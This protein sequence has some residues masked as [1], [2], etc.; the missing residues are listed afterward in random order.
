MKLDW[1]PASFVVLVGRSGGLCSSVDLARTTRAGKL[2]PR[3]IAKITIV[4]AVSSALA[5][6]EI[7]FARYVFVVA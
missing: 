4:L 3:Q 6:T 2:A 7:V 5:I 1:D